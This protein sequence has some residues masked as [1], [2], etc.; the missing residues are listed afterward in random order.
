[1]AA[2]AADL[3]EPLECQNRNALY[4]QELT[5]V[6]VERLFRERDGGFWKFYSPEPVEAFAT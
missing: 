6:L 4:N 2:S 1:M 3:L 5:L